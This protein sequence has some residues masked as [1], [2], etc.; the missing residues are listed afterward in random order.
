LEDLGV[1]LNPDFTD[2]LDFNVSD[3]VASTPP[4][5]WLFLRSIK[6]TYDDYPSTRKEIQTILLR[7]NKRNPPFLNQEDLIEFGQI[8]HNAE[9]AN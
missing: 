4:G 3:D 2:Y 9:P 5:N 1:N 8:K 7:L 6:R